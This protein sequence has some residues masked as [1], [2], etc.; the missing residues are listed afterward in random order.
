[1]DQNVLII[2]NWSLYDFTPI[3]GVRHRSNLFEY[4]AYT[5]DSTENFIKSKLSSIFVFDFIFYDIFCKPFPLLDFWRRK[6]RSASSFPLLLTH[7]SWGGEA[8]WLLCLW[9][10]SCSF[11]FF[12]LHCFFFFPQSV[13]LLKFWGTIIT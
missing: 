11:P 1:M 3:Q 4:N 13:F 6:I 9:K 2:Q 5:I 7:T 8:A 10:S 12:L